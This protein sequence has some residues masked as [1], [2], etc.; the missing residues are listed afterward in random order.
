MA[1]TSGSPIKDILARAGI[2]YARGKKMVCPQCKERK[3][4]ASPKGI[5][6][7]WG[8]GAFWTESTE[9]TSPDSDWAIYLLTKIASKCQTHLLG[10]IEALDYLDHRQIPINDKR[11]LLDQDIA[12][13]PPGLKISNWV[14]MADALL[15]TAIS[16]Q[17]AIM[18]KIMQK[19]LD[20]HKNS[21]VYKDA[22]KNCTAMQDKLDRE[23]EEFEHLTQHI[24]PLLLNPKWHNAMVYIYRDQ[25]GQPCSLN[26]R[27]FATEPGER[28]VMRIQPRSG[29]RGCF[30][31][32][33]AQYAAGAGWPK[34]FPALTIV[35]GEHNLLALQVAVERWGLDYFIPA[36]AVGGKNGADIACI[37]SLAKGT[38][39]LVVFDNDKLNP[40]TGRPGG[41]ELV[42]AVADQMY[43]LATTTPTKDMDDYL[44]AEPGIM[45][46]KLLR[47][48]FDRAIRV[49]INIDTVRTMVHD[50]LCSDE[51]ESNARELVVTDIIVRDAM[52]RT[53]LF[54]VD[55]YALLLQQAGDGTADYV[56]V[57]KGNA[58]LHCFLRGYGIAKPDW[59][60]AV[61]R[62]LNIVAMKLDTP[63]KTLHSISAW[64]HGR[65]Y[66]NCYEGS[67]VRIS[68]EDGKI[69]LDRVPTG[70]DGVLMHRYAHSFTD[71]EAKARPWLDPEFD[72]D[73]VDP[74]ALLH[75]PD[76]ML[77]KGILDRVT[78]TES[79]AHYKQLLKCWILSLFFATTQKS[80]PV[81]M[82]EGN[83]G[84]GKSSVGTAT[85]NVLIGE[86][87]TVTNAPQK[88][89]ELA[90]L[91]TGQPLVVFDEWSSIPKEVEKE[92]KS[93]TTGGTFKTRELYTTSTVVELSC[94]AAVMMTT[95][96]NPNK[97]V[98]I[99]R[100][101]IVVP[102]AAR[103]TAAGDEVYSSTGECLLPSLMAIR[104]EIWMEL[105]ADLSGCVLALHNTDP[106]TK[107]SFS[108]ADF[109]VF[110]MRIANH[111]G[112][113]DMA[114][115][116]FIAVEKKQEQQT[117]ESQPLAALI[118]EYFSCCANHE[119]RFFS[120]REWC[121]HFHSVI[122]DT[123]VELR[124]KVTANYV[125]YVFKVHA[126][127]Y[128]RQFGLELGED[129]HTKIKLYGLRLPRREPG[130]TQEAA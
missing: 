98:A 20:E 111:E 91:M 59:I 3:V 92:L 72:L 128:T 90:E 127:I 77:E 36:I 86:R 99:S 103:Q 95:N 84:G 78:Y 12:A 48:V 40:E 63:R 43:C 114:R 71:T 14:A 108:M 125:G 41:Y 26:I 47:D 8:C 15:K 17:Q 10:C 4:T 73:S 116:M 49:P 24:L 112:W 61:G 109:G 13:V 34:G 126:D 54:N 28:T 58:S 45:P 11:W 89:K 81:V 104:G 110:V 94:D 46:A 52:R 96:A 1:A 69:V 31:V 68:V 6:K 113:G 80:K 53:Q 93:L 16:S 124:R 39:P 19:V 5:A 38:E 51:F 123:D 75:D 117:I 105:L 88:G 57:R 76:S 27:Q 18:K 100:R 42:D 2:E 65:L 97:Q 33:N 35:E 37:A 82:F 22:L 129:A 115:K 79:P 55:G 67:M 64:V 60:D 23:T 74:G 122:P 83:A 107:T 120:A 85:G 44:V 56:P 21:K 130:V 70:Q 121:A 118:P 50:C 119:G 66:V 32:D 29:H 62:A 106:T 87:F 7:C 25:D 9:E 101:F 30:G 102:V